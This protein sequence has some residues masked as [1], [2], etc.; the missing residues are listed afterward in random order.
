MLKLEKH[1]L[2]YSEELSLCVAIVVHQDLCFMVSV[3]KYIWCLRSVS[4]ASLKVTDILYV[5]KQYKQLV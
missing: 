4:V 5:G 1:Y 2:I 3:S